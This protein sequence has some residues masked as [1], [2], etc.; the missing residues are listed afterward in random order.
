MCSPVESSRACATDWKP[1]PGPT[2]TQKLVELSTSGA[3]RALA[4]TWNCCG[5]F[6]S[7]SPKAPACAAPAIT[8]AEPFPSR[9]FQADMLPD[10]KPSEKTTFEYPGGVTG[11][12]GAESAPV[13]TLLIAATRKVYVV[14]LVSP[15]IVRVVA[16]VPV[17][18][19]VRGVAP[20]HGGRR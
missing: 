3:A 4:S 7:S 1:L 15:V 11:G 5:P 10:S 17:T 8:V 16:G 9:P 2:R 12:E 19:G 14:P 6:E 20:M 18:I 13:P